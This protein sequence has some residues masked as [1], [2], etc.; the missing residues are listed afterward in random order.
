MPWDIEWFSLPF[1][2]PRENRRDIQPFALRTERKFVSKTTLPAR[3]EE[4]TIEKETTLVV[5]RVSPAS[6]NRLTDEGAN[7]VGH[8]WLA[9][10]DEGIFRRFVPL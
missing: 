5:V 4:R 10:V 1:A 8:G 7:V 9:N 2:L 3:G 6:R